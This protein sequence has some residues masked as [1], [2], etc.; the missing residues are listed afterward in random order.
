MDTSS[1][2][3]SY[4]VRSAQ[5]EKIPFMIIVGDKEVEENKVTIRLRNGDNLEIDS[6]DEAI[7]LINKKIESKEAI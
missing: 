5:K 7:D 2:T 4:R 6:L 3:L 1:N